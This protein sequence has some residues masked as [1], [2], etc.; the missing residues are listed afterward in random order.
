MILHNATFVFRE[1]A[2]VLVIEGDRIAAIDRQDEIPEDLVADRERIDLDGAAVLPGFVD[3]HVHLFDAGLTELGWRV[4]L[5]GKSR[6]ETLAALAEG[7]RS[8]GEGDWLIGAGW[9]ESGWDDRRYLTR[10]ELD[11]VSTRSPIGAV[12]MDGHLLVANSAAFRVLDDRP[13]AG[14]DRTLADRGTGQIREE[15]VWR[16]LESIEPD[17][18]TLFDALGAAAGL[19]HRHGITSV[20]AMTSESRLPVLVRAGGR[21]RLRVNAYHKVSAPAE[22]DSVRVSGGF[23]GN[24]LRFGGIKAFADGSLGAGNAAVGTPYPGGGTGALNHDEEELAEIVRR[25][26]R[27]GWQTAFHAIGDRAIEQV[28]RVH[29]AVETSPE[30]RHRIEHA[31]LASRDQIMRAKD[32]GLTLSMQPNFIGN[33]SGPGSMNERRLG[34]ARDEA[35]NPLR[36]VLG[37]GTPLAFGSDGMPV[38]PLYGLHSAVN[39]PYGSQRI[40]V[41]EAIAAYTAGGARLS[42]EE[43]VKGALDVGAYADLV[44]LD[45]DPRLAPD[46]L[47]DRRIVRVI[48]GGEEVFEAGEG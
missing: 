10:R 7:V 34:R 11:R 8:R 40:G 6:D 13:L 31:E 24:W 44:V 38:S 28:L 25:S 9:D 45:E 20:H 33:W 32:L 27:A 22:I 14:F 1:D 4:D 2:E 15:S 29:A 46:R 5:S 21:N 35:S 3:A 30:L 39:G 41:D 23:D 47:S 16:L 12:R 19:C 42:F 18:A 36:W 26:E 37:A 17:E 48:V 43:D